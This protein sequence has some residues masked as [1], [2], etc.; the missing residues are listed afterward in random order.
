M[1]ASAGSSRVAVA[2]SNAGLWPRALGREPFHAY[3]E[4]RTGVKASPWSTSSPALG[5]H[6]WSGGAERG[7]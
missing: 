2:A 7:A 4:G 6:G 3:A 1:P 5:Q